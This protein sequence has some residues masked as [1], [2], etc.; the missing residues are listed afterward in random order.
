MSLKLSKKGVIPYLIR[1]LLS[2]IKAG[3]TGSGSGMTVS[4][5]NCLIERPF[6]GSHT[7]LLPNTTIL[8]QTQTLKKNIY[9]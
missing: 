2:L 7:C 4:T 5:M 1:D 3:D 6:V 8:Y 9:E